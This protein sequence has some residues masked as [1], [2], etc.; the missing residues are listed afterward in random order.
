MAWGYAPSMNAN[1]LMQAGE[2]YWIYLKQNAS[3]AGYSYTPIKEI[4]ENSN[5]SATTTIT[6]GGGAGV[7]PGIISQ[8]CTAFNI[9]ESVD[10]EIPSLPAAFYGTVTDQNGNS[11]SE[12]TIEVVVNGVVQASKKFKDGKF[13]MSLGERLIVEKV[14]SSEVYKIEF[15]VNDYLAHANVPI[16]WESAFG[17]LNSLQLKVDMSEP[18]EFVL[19][20][21]R[22]VNNTSVELIFSKSL[23][24]S[25]INDATFKKAI[26][27]STNG[28]DY[29]SLNPA[30]D[31][32]IKDNKLL[33]TF[34]QA[35]QGNQNQLKIAGNTLKDTGGTII[36]DSVTTSA[37][38]SGTIDECFIATAAF[39]SKFE[40]AV[41]LL[42]H[43]RDQYL[44]TNKLG[45]AFVGFYYHNSPPI[46]AYI[47]HSEPLKV[48]V[49][50]L[51]I[52]IIAV[53]YSF[54]HPVMG[55]GCILVLCF[56]LVFGKHR[57]KVINT[58]Q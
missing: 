13:G 10:A 37:F 42:R 36:V 16:E 2:G 31:V 27:I 46:A 25:L 22:P 47:A 19:Q 32:S 15:I 54:M 39:G 45:T 41:V 24:P 6:A 4:A 55:G 44:L 38:S 11:L 7:S 56:I 48:F 26:S 40:P 9:A 20:A 1:P 30:D 5:S 14:L 17:E 33:I 52:P 57:K 18:D 43:F 50:M 23:E 53:A 21:V 34:S 58:P 28:T 8:S 12:G 3:L 49:R 51:L 35:L 29:I